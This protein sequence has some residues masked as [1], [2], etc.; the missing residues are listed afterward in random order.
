MKTVTVILTCKTKAYADKECAWYGQ[1]EPMNQQVIKREGIYHVVRDW[2]P[3]DEG[4]NYDTLE[5]AE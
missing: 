4:R 3:S 2:H 5:V 1:A